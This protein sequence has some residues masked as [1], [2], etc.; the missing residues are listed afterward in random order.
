MSDNQ[1]SMNSISDKVK[2]V[3]NSF[4]FIVKG[5]ISITMIIYIIS[6]FSFISPVLKVLVN[7]P[8]T[9]IFNFYIWTIITTFLVTPSLLNILF[10]FM[11]WVPS[12]M[13][14][15]R[16]IGSTRFVMNILTRSIIIQI[17]Y[18]LVSLLFAIIFGKGALLLPSTGLWPL[19]MGD[20]TISCIS[21]PDREYM[22]FFVPFP[23][24]GK[25]Y[26]WVLI[27][28]FTIL[29][30]QFQFDLICGVLFGYL[31]VYKLK[32]YIEYS[33]ETV[34]KV[35]NSTIFSCLI[36]FESYIKIQSISSGS[37]NYGFGSSNNRFNNDSENNSSNTNN[38]TNNNNLESKNTSSKPTTAFQ[39][40]GVAFGS[41]DSTR[42]N[43][44]NVEK[45]DSVSENINSTNNNKS[46]LGYGNLVQDTSVSK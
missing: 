23:I 7:I 25:Y 8:Y 27:T 3:W 39:G 43:Y 21:N 15:E 16:E 18:I 17:L 26:P 35:E 9:T 4:P 30:F 20:I 31:Y 44:Q 5:I 14:L 13:M 40:K 12:S 45:L 42:N 28:F 11:S 36:N 46:E 19:I 29:N 6:W 34:Q 1:F 10:A 22:F 32:E 33:S 41:T 37:G 2:A 24:K 38:N